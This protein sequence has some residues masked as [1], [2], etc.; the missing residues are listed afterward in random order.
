MDPRRRN[1]RVS[2]D[3]CFAI[4]NQYEILFY[5]T[6]S[7]LYK[8]PAKYHGYGQ[9]QKRFFL[10]RDN[11]LYQFHEKPLVQDLQ[12]I[13]YFNN[14][15]AYQQLGKNKK[16]RVFLLSEETKIEFLNTRNASNFFG[17]V[18]SQGT[19]ERDYLSGCVKLIAS[20]SS[21]ETLYLRLRG[22]KSRELAWI[23][24]LQQT[25]ELQRMSESPAILHIYIFD[26]LID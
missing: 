15:N 7:W 8:W 9:L 24:A 22:Q 17:S 19:E 23:H 5:H 12:Q 20:P 21:D 16:F 6:Y 13:I 14:S 11:L 25:I 1:Q 10:L 18:Q 3:Q 2:H 26:Y 4:P